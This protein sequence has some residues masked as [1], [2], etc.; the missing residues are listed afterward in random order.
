MCNR[1]KP[2]TKNNKN[3]RCVYTD[4]D[5]EDLVL[6]KI[7]SLKILCPNFLS[8]IEMLKCSKYLKEYEIKTPK[9]VKD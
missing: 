9:I 7:K 2:H 8:P 3:R 6:N 5:S 1:N 4:G